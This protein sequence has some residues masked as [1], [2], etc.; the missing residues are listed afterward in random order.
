MKKIRFT[1]VALLIL[2]VVELIVTKD[3]GYTGI[4]WILYGIY[5]LFMSVSI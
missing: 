2:S 1:V 3:L 4:L 5:R